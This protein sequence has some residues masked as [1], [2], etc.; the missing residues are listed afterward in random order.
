VR[1]PRIEGAVKLTSF[2]KPMLAESSNRPAFSDSGYIFEIKWDGYH[3]VAEVAQENR[4][5]SRNGTSYHKAFPRIFE[6]L[7]KIKRPVIL[8]GEVVVY[9]ET[10][11]P[12]FQLLQNYNSRQNLPIQFQVFDCLS[13]D[14]KDLC[15]LP[16]IERKEILRKIL[17]KSN[18][19]P[20]CDHVEAEGQLLFDQIAKL[21]LEG[22]IAKKASSKYSMGNRTKDWLKIKNHKYGDFLVVGFLHSDKAIF[23]SLVLADA[24]HGELTYRGH[25][26]GF[27]DK[28]MKAIYKLLTAATSKAKPVGKHEKFDVPVTWVKPLYKCN[29][30]YTEITGDGILRHPIFQNMVFTGSGSK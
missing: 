13:L 22:M 7:K 12:S 16:L 9:N 1:Y 27:S 28:A 15:G 2:I 20:Y 11:K 4:I 18:V 14:G 29:V 19:I 21:D 6:E 26:S 8:D 23:K 10:G 3:C 5:Y 24:E 30:R 25:V 17:P